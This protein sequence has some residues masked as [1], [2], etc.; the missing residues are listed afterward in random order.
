MRRSQ[1]VAAIL[2]CAVLGGCSTLQRDLV[3]DFFT[4]AVT[5]GHMTNIEAEPGQ[6]VVFLDP[7]RPEWRGRTPEIAA[8]IEKLIAA[9]TVLG[10]SNEIRLPIRVGMTDANLRKAIASAF[11]SSVLVLSPAALERWGHGL[12]E[13][14]AH[15]FAHLVTAFWIPPHSAAWLENCKL[16]AAA[17]DTS[18]GFRHECW[19]PR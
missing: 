5:A 17:L 15:E 4:A 19:M 2:L 10:F 6:S 13:I 9:S 14:L 3:H 7:E 1:F 11:G 16:L 18:D 12:E 8:V